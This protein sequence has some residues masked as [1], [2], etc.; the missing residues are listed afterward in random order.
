MWAQGGGA[1]GESR[2]GAGKPGRRDAHPEEPPVSHLGNH[3][4]LQVVVHQI[5]QKM[6]FLLNWLKISNK[7]GV[8][9]NYITKTTARVHNEN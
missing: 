7:F 9:K 2:G 4:L 5:L 1:S 8:K 6:F 3:K